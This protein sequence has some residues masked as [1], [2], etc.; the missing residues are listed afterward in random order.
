MNVRQ[1]IMRKLTLVALVLSGVLASHSQAGA[2][3][4]E[5]RAA[6][7]AASG[8]ATGSVPP[9]AAALGYTKR[10]IHETQ[11]AAD[12]APGKNGNYKWFSGQWYSRTAPSLDHYTTQD[13]VL[14]PSLGGDLVSTPRD[15][16]AGKLPLLSGADGF[17]VEFDVR[18]SDNDRDHWPA[19]WLMPA[20]H[21][22]K[23]DHYEPDS[24]ASR[25]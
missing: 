25:R 1:D 15:F 6:G 14:A 11:T 13:G 21:D 8:R 12:V 16:S 9:G 3:G 18:L 7:K 4:S 22:G 5:E 23:R 2:P 20:E 19:V 10:V 24:T 17:Y